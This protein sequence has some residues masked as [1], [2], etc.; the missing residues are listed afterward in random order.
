MQLAEEV[1]SRAGFSISAAIEIS[2]LPL[3]F[4]NKAVMLLQLGRLR[5]GFEFYEY[6]RPVDDLARLRWNGEAEVGGSL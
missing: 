1:D 6:R 5:A 3:F 2:P 4:Q